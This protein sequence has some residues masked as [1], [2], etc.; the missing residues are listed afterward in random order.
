MTIISRPLSHIVAVSGCIALCIFGARVVYGMED[1]LQPTLEGILYEVD[2]NQ[3][4]MI[5]TLRLESSEDGQ[6]RRA[7]YRTPRGNVVTT[8]ELLLEGGEFKRFNLVHHEAGQVGQVRRIGERV[9]FSYTKN[10]K[11][12]TRSEG[13]V[14]NFVIGPMVVPYIQSHWKDLVAGEKLEIRFGVPHRLRSYRFR[15]V[16]E[17]RTR[18]RGQ[19]AVV[20]KVRPSNFILSK[21]VDPIYFTF[22]PDGRSVLEF[23]GRTAPLQHIGGRWRPTV[24]TG[25]FTP[26]MVAAPPDRAGDN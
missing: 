3:E 19:D 9:E 15:I 25:V 8:Q 11:T 14:P 13:L 6:H 20:L 10:G 1:G 12:R 17:K 26:V 23:V 16:R 22:S 7:E 4:E 18:W 24:A 5:F 2:S 21:F